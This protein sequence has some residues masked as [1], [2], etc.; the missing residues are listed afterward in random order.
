[1]KP[2]RWP[3]VEQLFHFAL[4]VEESR[5]SAFLE[6]SCAGDE[7]LRRE[8]ELLLGADKKAENFLES[9]AQEIV[10]QGGQVNPRS[11][12]EEEDSRLPGKTVSH[13]RILEKLGGGGMGV[14]YRAQDL[15]LDRFVAL[16]FLPEQTPHDLQAVEQLQR[17]ARAASA[18]NHPH[19][20]TIHDIDEHEGRP[21]MV[22]EML[23]GQTLKR[24]IA[25]KPLEKNEIV[26]LGIQ[27][28]DALEAAHAREI[29][30]RDIKPANIFVTPRGQVKILD[31][32]LAKLL[33]TDTAST[34]TAGIA[35]TRAFV[36][37]L[38]Y[39]APEQLQGKGVSTR[40]DIYAIGTVLYEM[41]TGRCPFTEEFAPELVRN[42]LE[43]Q[44]TR[45]RELNPAVS[46][47]LEIIILKCLEKE[48]EKRYERVHQLLEDLQR[49]RPSRAGRPLFAAETLAGLALV[50]AVAIIAWRIERARLPAADLRPAIRSIAI[51]PLA[52]LSG[53][54]EQEY[55]ADGM[56]EQLTTDLGQI[57]ALRVISRT[58]AMHYKGTKKKLP[59][60]VREL[61]VDAVIE[62]SVERA[63]NQVRITAQLVEARTD[64]HLWA[65]SYVRDL[66]DV[67]SL[68]DDVAKEI[69]GEI[70]I[71]LTP[72][73]RSRLS[74]ARPVD[75]TANEAYLR[76]LHEL[77]GMT[78]EPTEALKSQSIEKAIGYFQLALSHDPNDALVYSGLADAYSSLSPF[79]RAPLQV[80]PKAKAAAT[81]AVEL[82]DTLAEAHAS[83]GYVS[84]TFDWDWARAEHEFR[85]ALELNPSSSR[86]HSGYAQYLM[87]VSGHSEQAIQELQ[88]AYALDPLLPQAHGDLA[89]F[90]FLA[91][92]YTE[93]I[94][95]GLRVGRDDHILALSYAELGQS[96]Q[97]LAAADRAAKS[98]QSP[99]VL[100]QTA[101]A[102]ALA[103]RKDKARAMTQG[104][105]GQ[106]RKRYVCGFNVACLYSVLGDKEHAF[107]WLEKAYR[108]RSD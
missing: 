77:H 50:A 78:A 48:P 11:Q 72:Q 92:R 102:Y 70:K 42:I 93:S 59:E 52:N 13:Y 55:F 75:P 105:E 90:L 100:S 2:E 43:V 60:I 24:R 89:W 68:Q 84:L 79:Y 101:A 99:V 46:P 80:M 8:V 71:V 4:K 94:E 36:G 18:L 61:S 34:L 81:R 95:A 82:D 53:D 74:N 106:A 35:E 10:R 7:D 54:A 31:F 98:T 16:K 49:L 104:I 38:P 3:R 76:G 73:E 58:S 28:A 45:P 5:R 97:A 69:A 19:I 56:T 64:R 108:D 67:L 51:L 22:M 30:H 85:R 86:A 37:T 83:L 6:E 39:M 87:F 62:G 91:R 9:P 96:E 21:F 47:D 44:P 107:A 29:I 66:R 33:P 1:M 88:Q 40:T 57:S 26:S 15:R 65:K 20:C 17:E 25:G 12:A 41:A 23:E 63:G 27:V 103:G 14:V 32:G